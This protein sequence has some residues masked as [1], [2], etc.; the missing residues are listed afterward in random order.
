MSSEA[1]ITAALALPLAGAAL[2]GLF[3]RRPNVR[4]TATLLTGLSLF[5]VVVSLVA[6]VL[7]G[8]RPAVTLLELF[9]GPLRLRPEKS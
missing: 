1:A 2:V 7:A 9:P 4:E 6:P 3:G 5:A 8:E